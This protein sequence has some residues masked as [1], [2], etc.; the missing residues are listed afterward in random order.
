MQMPRNNVIRSSQVVANVLQVVCKLH[1]S[2]QV[3]AVSAGAR[4]QLDRRFDR[5]FTWRSLGGSLVHRSGPV[6]CCYLFLVIC[7]LLL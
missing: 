1:K 2:S 3:V 6:V 4:L 7:K 5:Q